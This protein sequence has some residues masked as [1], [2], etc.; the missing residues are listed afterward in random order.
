MVA[1][2]LTCCHLNHISHGTHAPCLAFKLLSDNCAWHLFATGWWQTQY[3]HFVA[4]LVMPVFLALISGRQRQL[5]MPCPSCS[6]FTVTQSSGSLRFLKFPSALCCC[7]LQRVLR[8]YSVLVMF[9]LVQKQL[10]YSSVSTKPSLF[11][12]TCNVL[13]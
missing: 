11:S 13:N 4:D 1:P 8:C 12:G 3:C 5:P 6:L 2:P 7:L 9:A 10:A